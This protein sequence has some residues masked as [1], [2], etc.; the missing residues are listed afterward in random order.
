M[1]ET[2]AMEIPS[3]ILEQRIQNAVKPG[4]AETGLYHSFRLPD[5]RIL[6]GSMDLDWQFE[7]VA[8]FGLP[9]DL[10]GKTVLDIGPWDG[11]FTFEMERRGA[12]VT[13]IDYVDLDTFRELHRA[14]RSKA[15]YLRMDVYELDAER[16]GTFDI[17]LCL[18]AL[19]HFKHPLAALEKICAIT[20]EV[21]F[22]DTFVVDAEKRAPLPYMEFYEREELGGQFDNWCGPTVSAVEA[23]VRSAGFARAELKRVAGSTACVAGWRKWPGEPSPAA[24]RIELA[25]LHSHSD[26]GRSF[27]SSK[28][29][30]IKLWCP[31]ER[32][33]APTFDEVFPEID[34]FGVA[35]LSCT[36]VDRWVV[37]SVRVPPGLKPGRHEGRI[38]IGQSG[39]S[40]PREFYLDLP[41]IANR[42]ELRAV[43]DS[44][45]WQ[46][47]D[48]DWVNGGWLTLW[49]EGLS[50]EADP[51]NVLVEVA[52]IPHVP[53][54]VDP[55]KGQVNIHLR[56]LVR[57]GE[58]EIRLLHRGAESALI[59]K[60]KGQAP[61]IRG[62]ENL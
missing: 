49:A 21:C 11:F 44:I 43:Q 48:V 34:G 31:W 8:S 54:A 13:A 32:T 50:A 14:F 12:A 24:P 40:E 38:R 18:G 51:G 47:G 45:T 58:H 41:P 29:E 39:W 61:K 30:Y 37:V 19:Y 57:A 28:E 2:G 62:L 15:R 35:P 60:V 16:L 22:V 23:M 52:G 7:R 55:A 33:G 6:R 53:D 25:R 10:R 5:G 1:V 46:I 27:H 20:N 59:L 4:L 56:P 17:V 26:P 3:D 9:E 42:M 36:I